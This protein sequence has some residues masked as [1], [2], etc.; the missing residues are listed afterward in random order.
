[1][2]NKTL[3]LSATLKNLHQVLYFLRKRPFRDGLSHTRPR[4]LGPTDDS[5]LLFSHSY[6]T[7]SS[8]NFISYLVK[9]L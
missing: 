6:D 2:R 1:M 9:Q 5:L 8:L 7:L 4:Y 3:S